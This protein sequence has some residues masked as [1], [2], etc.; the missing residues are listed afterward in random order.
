VTT[1]T[2]RY[3]F[4]PPAAD[5]IPIGAL[6]SATQGASALD[7][8]A[9]TPVGRNFLAHALV[10]LARDGWLCADADADAAWEPDDERPARPTPT[11]EDPNRAA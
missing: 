9:S 11:P 2:P 3:A 5:G 1:A 4:I 7:A 10:Q 8:W 6:D